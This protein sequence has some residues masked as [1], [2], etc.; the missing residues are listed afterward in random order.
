NIRRATGHISGGDHFDP[1][2]FRLDRVIEQREA[3]AIIAARFIEQILVADF[4]IAEVERRRMP[5]VCALGAPGGLC[6]T[7]GRLDGVECILY[8]GAKLWF[9]Y[10]LTIERI[11]R[12]QTQDSGRT[13][14]VTHLQILMEPQPV[15]GEVTPWPIMARSFSDVA[16]RLFPVPT[17]CDV[18]TL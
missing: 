5:V 7:D 2:V 14:I 16:D 6:V 12:E 1:G 4:D 8:V 17:L 9:R 15:A 13:E 10:D 3:V 11:T 18:P